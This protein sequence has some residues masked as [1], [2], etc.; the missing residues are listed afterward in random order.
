MN[1][2]NVYLELKSRGLIH[3]TTSE[4]I[5]EHLTNQQTVYC[6]FDPTGDSLHVGHLLPIIILKHFEN[7][8]HKNIAVIGGATGLIG[9]PSGK[10]DERI[11]ND[12][13]TVTKFSNTIKSQL[14]KYLESDKTKFVN[15]YDWFGKISALDFLRNYGKSFGINYMINKESVSSRLE[16][17]LSYTEFSYTIIQAMDFAHLYSKYNC[18]IQIGG[19]DQWGNITSGLELIRKENSESKAYGLTIPLVTKSDGTK[20]GKTEG[21][22]IWLDSKKTSP[23]EFYQFF[24][25]TDDLDVIKYL[26]FFTFLNISEIEELEKETSQNPHLRLAQKKLAQEITKFVHGA[27]VLETV[28]KLSKALFSGNLNELSLSEIEENISSIDLIEI[29]NNSS[30]LETLIQANLASS[31]REGREFINSRAIKVNGEIVLDEKFIVGEEKAI[32]GVYILIKRG[33]KKYAFLKLNT[34]YEK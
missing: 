31:N 25:N 10:K 19:S 32:G 28:E 21:N 23:Y 29:N 6:G 26:K 18:S 12:R 14:T 34:T 2:N 11:L 17:G 7:Y 13:E 24:L 33:K 16:K 27:G 9:D 1:Y 22:A 15:N 8:G 20:F 3:Q 4:E 30:I 5:I